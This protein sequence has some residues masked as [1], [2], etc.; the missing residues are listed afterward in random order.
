MT[1]ACSVHVRGAV[2][3]VGFRPFVFRLARAHRLT[4][5][6][7]NGDDG[8]KILV[9]GPENKVA[10]FLRELREQPP[11]AARITAIDVSEAAPTGARDFAIR[12]SAHG[13][14]PTTRIVPDLAV[15]EACV[16][17]LFDRSN[18]RFGYPYINC[19][20]CGPRYTVIQ[21]L[22][23]D[24]PNTTMWR[25]RMDEACVAEYEDPS[26]RR[27]HA[28]P[29]AC[30]HCGPGYRL[31]GPT[32]DAL[33]DDAHIPLTLPSP[34]S[35]A[36]GCT[37]SPRLRGESWG[38]G[39]RENDSAAGIRAAARL[40]TEGAIVAIKGLGGYHLACDAANRRAVRNLRD[41]KYRKE[42]PFAL[43]ARDLDTARR[44][45]VLTRASE[46]L[47]TSAARPI[48]LAPVA[49]PLDLPAA[50]AI[51]LEG[52]APGC[53][54]LGVMLPYTPLH[55]LLFSA[56]APPAI[57]LTS[58]NRSS[59]PIA[60]EDDDA[61]Q[62]LAGLADAFLIGERP[63]ARRVDDS[64]VRAGARGPMILRRA[65]GYAPDAV[66]VLPIDRPVIAVGGD[67]KNAITVAVDGQAF[68]SQHIGDLDQADC[69]RAFRETIDDLTSMYEIDW[70]D[71]IVAHDAHPEYVSTLT[72]LSLP[73]PRTIAIQHHRAHL[74]SVLAERG[75]WEV[76]VLGIACDGTGYG[77]DGVIW[78]GELFTGSVREG[79]RRAAHLR[80]APLPGG[81]A[82]AR[83][84]V[85]A[86]AGFLTQ[87]DRA[88]HVIDDM[89]EAPFAF[90]R[91]YLDARRLV[92]RGLRTFTTTSMGRLFDAAAALLGFTRAVTFEGQAAI[93]LEQLARRASARTAA[94]AS[95]PFPFEGDQLDFRPLLSAVIEERRRGRDICE[96]ARGFQHGVAD[97]LAA[98]AVALCA[99]H[100]CRAIVLSGGVFQNELLL[101]DLARRLSITGL[102]IWTNHSV[103]PNDG[104]LSLGQAALAALAPG[105]R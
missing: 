34:L 73:A 85:Q 75:A 69:L 39:S 12:Q 7:A 88:E 28:Q 9:Q 94:H 8:V 82:A 92:T 102:P 43:M 97:G 35:G 1:A 78:G 27:F 66:A 19:T 105:D 2:Q 60:Y 104:G 63:I 31:R 11:P 36:R 81:D 50:A 65:R 53:D 20:H 98:A 16:A 58:A 52:V 18:R 24:R 62:R 29:I 95:Y 10:A 79:F 90:P 21:G 56:G 46:A 86:A 68:V 83:C 13:S 84:P 23:Y 89:L 3:G 25:W 70:R 14:R 4:G 49:E 72:A 44:L 37:P 48:V 42:K 45:V 47:L 38:E 59:E 32:G 5:W 93:W 55:H 64:V 101:Q 17:E 41:R 99:R 103:P 51:D 91:R 33:E 30:R 100:T 71:A 54:E 61:K 74:A 67:L 76:S 22:P 57:V 80:P 6:V 77:D 87:I 15:C 96:I 26:D 40:L